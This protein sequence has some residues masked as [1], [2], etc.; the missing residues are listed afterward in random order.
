MQIEACERQSA[1]GIF[2]V[3]GMDFRPAKNNGSGA[4]YEW[5]ADPRKSIDI[6]VR[7]PAW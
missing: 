2:Q 3:G 1:S 4:S 6:N 7:A 5:D